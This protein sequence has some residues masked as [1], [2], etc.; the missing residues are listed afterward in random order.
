MSV[1]KKE[2]QKKMLIKQTINA[3]NKQIQKL[4]EQKK[5]YIE[6]GKK[7]KQQGLSAQYKRKI[8]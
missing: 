5:T 2:I 3:M 4:E 1:T 6:A 7:A 8:F